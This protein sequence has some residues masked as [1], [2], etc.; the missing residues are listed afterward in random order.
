MWA[1]LL[2]FPRGELRFQDN[3]GVCVLTL[4]PWLSQHRDDESLP[5]GL[6]KDIA[7][8]AET[9][10][11]FRTLQFTYGVMLRGATLLESR[12]RGGACIRAQD[13][14][15]GA[16]LLRWVRGRGG[17]WATSIREAAADLAEALCSSGETGR[18]A[19]LMAQ[20]ME[21]DYEIDCRRARG[22][23]EE[24][25]LGGEHLQQST[26]LRNSET[27]HAPLTA[28]SSWLLTPFLSLRGLFLQVGS[29]QESEEWTQ[30][31]MDCQM[32]AADSPSFQQVS[33]R[34]ASGN[35]EPFPL[36]PSP[37]VAGPA[38]KLSSGS[39]RL[40]S[41]DDTKEGD[42]RAHSASGSP[43]YSG[44]GRPVV[45]SRSKGPFR[46]RHSNSP[47]PKIR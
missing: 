1:F 6:S 3:S 24:V 43:R 23:R 25:G 37:D 42:S 15:S 13:L 16:N 14:R 10:E 44:D 18:S 20:D 29:R 34:A 31:G 40:E 11:K 4:S 28:R 22:H 9:E 17:P 26:Q 21:M 19:K 41:S 30:E 45:L 12:S 35:M 47:R 33:S 5:D 8:H 2:R 46:K 7:A 27:A 36:P 32:E 38:A 39:G